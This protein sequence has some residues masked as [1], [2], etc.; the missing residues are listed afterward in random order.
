MSTE[1]ETNTQPLPE[2]PYQYKANVTPGDFRI[3]AGTVVISNPP[4]LPP[5]IT[6][7]AEERVRKI[8]GTESIHA[9]E[10]YTV[11][12]TPEVLQEQ[13]YSVDLTNETI[14][15]LTSSYEAFLSSMHSIT[16][17]FITSDMKRKEGSPLGIKQGIDSFITPET[18]DASTTTE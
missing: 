7:T 8:D 16:N 6:F 14:T 9:T 10:T 11:T 1:P 5:S 3:V 13:L 12:L 2:F 17:L 18:T 4:N 15:G